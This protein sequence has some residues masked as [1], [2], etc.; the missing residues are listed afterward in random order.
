MNEFWVEFPA[1]Q[2]FSYSTLPV[3]SEPK[4]SEVGCILDYV[5]SQ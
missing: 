3:L 1:W 2:L 5:N 4:E